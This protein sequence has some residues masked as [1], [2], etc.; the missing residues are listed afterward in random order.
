MATR[1][2]H[3]APKSQHAVRNRIQRT[4]GAYQPSATA[5]VDLA[6]LTALVGFCVRITQLQVF[7]QFHRELW[8]RHRLHPGAYSALVAIKANP[9]V[10]PGALASALAVKRPNMTKLLDALE[11]DGWLE[12]RWQKADGRT[13]A[14]H[15]TKDGKKRISQI[16]DEAL[17][18]DA[19]ATA[20]L[21]DRERRQLR[22]LLEKVTTH[23]RRLN[24]EASP[25]RDSL[26]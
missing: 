20:C 9:G 14:L 16:A 1:S 3:A 13:V 24:E 10:Q 15:L 26:R 11:H 18:M 7:E 25:P 17:A 6:P 21:T 8:R 12:R 19:Y 22:A 23:L 5:A 4:A 2:R